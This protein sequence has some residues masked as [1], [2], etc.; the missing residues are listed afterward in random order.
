M[1]YIEFYASR[2]LPC[3]DCSASVSS[4]ECSQKIKIWRPARAGDLREE[5]FSTPTSAK[6]NFHILSGKCKEYQKKIAQNRTTIWKLRKKVKDLENLLS[7]FT[8]KNLISEEAA[9]DINVSN[10]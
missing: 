9:A 10:K 1:K 8:D 4:P 6:R 2:R 7:Q 3:T 5:H